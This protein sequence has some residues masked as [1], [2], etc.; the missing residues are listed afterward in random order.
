M[1]T[2][3]Y[4]LENILNG[5][6]TQCFCLKVVYFDAWLLCHPHYNLCLKIAMDILQLILKQIAKPTLGEKVDGKEI[7][8][9]L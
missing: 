1:E 2:C 7:T 3:T 8:I 6:H 5:L 4:F 9:D